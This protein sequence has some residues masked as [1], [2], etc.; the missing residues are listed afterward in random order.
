MISYELKPTFDNLKKSILEDSVGRNK[1]IANFIKLLDEIDGNVA[2]ALDDNWGNGKTFFVKQTQMVL[3][4]RISSGEELNDVKQCMEKLLKIDT[5]RNYLP[6]YYDAWSNDNDTDPVLSIIFT[7]LQDIADLE[8]YEVNDKSCWDMVTHG[9]E[10]L[11]RSFGGPPLKAFLDSVKGKNLLEEIKKRKQS[12]QVLNQLFDT[13]LEK[14]PEDTRILFFIDEL[15]R[16]CP[17]FAVR[18]LERIKH[19]FLHE[20]IIFVLSVNMSELQHTVK[21]HYGNDFNADKYL[22]RFFDFTIPLPSADMKKYYETINFGDNKAKYEIA[23]LV[24]EK[25]NFSLREITRYLQYL[26]VAVPERY[27]TYGYPKYSFYVEILTPFLIGLKVHDSDK[28]NDFISGKDM[29][30]FVEIILSG[31]PDSFCG[32]LINPGEETFKNKDTAQK[33]FVSL[34]ERFKPMYECL[35]GYNDS[36]KAVRILGDTICADDKKIIMEIMSLMR[37]SQNLKGDDNGNK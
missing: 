18:L 26:K 20:K 7:M 36:A 13:L 14:Q 16:C 8:D 30:C 37:A 34:E 1:S 15:D 4:S 3:Q 33:T 27:I 12:D 2:I 21:R 6:V 5:M 25:Y 10:V 9:F 24:M 19:Y 35:F 23:K 29:S 31:R 32:I 22:R 11:T 28:Y 17:D